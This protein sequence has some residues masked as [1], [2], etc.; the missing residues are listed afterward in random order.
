MTVPV[1]MA[2]VVARRPI[3]PGMVRV[4]FG[5]D[6]LQ[7][8]TSTGIGDEYVRLHLPHPATGDL[9]LPELDERGNWR[10]PEGK[11]P[12][13][14]AAYTVR[15]SDAVRGE[16]EI[17]FVVHAGGRASEW[18]QAAEP[19]MRLAIGKP[20]A[21]YEAPA[22]ARRQLFVCDATG[23]PAL[24]RLLEQLD[25]DIEA[26]V[27]VEIAEAAHEVSFA[28][29]SRLQLTWL[30]GSG[31]GVAASRLLEAIRGV[32]LPPGPGYIWVAGEQR[33]VRP[34]RKYLRHE[35]GLAA[36]RYSVV[37]YWTAGQAEWDAGWKALDPAIKDRISEA[38]ASGRDREEVEDE[39]EETLETFGL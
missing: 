13:H 39:V 7:A 32:T 25:A 15:R 27:I 9:V 37:G 28:S 23:I 11:T 4:T 22:E 2:E 35:L 34:I 29:A 38:W 16:V 21:I 1:L 33:S 17:D 24:G 8:F 14:Q 20:H 5:G 30:H 3:T 36:E 12:S 6:G 19:G 18:A 31:N 10:Y 26:K